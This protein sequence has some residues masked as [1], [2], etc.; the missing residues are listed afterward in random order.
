MIRAL[1]F[2]TYGWRKCEAVTSLYDAAY[3][4]WRRANWK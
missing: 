2:L 4:D 1:R 3:R